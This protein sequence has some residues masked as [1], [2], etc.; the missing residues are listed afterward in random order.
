MGALKKGLR[1]KASWEVLKGP[2]VA[3]GGPESVLRGPGR[4]GDCGRPWV[5]DLGESGSLR[6]GG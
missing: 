1:P 5:G 4:S 6:W 3:K 2:K